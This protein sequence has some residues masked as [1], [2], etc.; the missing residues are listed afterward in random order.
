MKFQIFNL[1]SVASF[2]KQTNS[3][4]VSEVFGEVGEAVKAFVAE[5]LVDETILA[6][7]ASDF[8]LLPMIENGGP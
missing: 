6:L 1:N 3:V 4:R 8:P 5:R 7:P 2:G